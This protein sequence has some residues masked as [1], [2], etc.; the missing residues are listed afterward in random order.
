MRCSCSSRVRSGALG[1]SS[2]TP[3][4]SPRPRT[5]TTPGT[6]RSWAI[7]RSPSAAAWATRPSRSVTS[8]TANA[9]AQARCAPPNVVPSI[10][11]RGSML[12]AIISA[13]TGKPLPMPLAM[14]ITSGRIPAHWCAKN[15]PVRPAPLCTSSKISTTPYSRQSRLS[16][17]KNSALGSTTP[18][19]PWMPS[20]MAAA[21][22]SPSRSKAARNVSRSFSCT[23]ST[24]CWAFRGAMMGASSVTATAALVRPCH[25]PVKV[26][27]RVRPV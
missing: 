8:T 15:L 3:I 4:M 14:V 21:K 25:P 2:C 9:A 19:T 16:S 26:S 1:C 17:C 27:T 7:Q 20:T 24:L 6:W 13:P 18:A 23:V 22:L 5:S 12:G 10:P 11:I